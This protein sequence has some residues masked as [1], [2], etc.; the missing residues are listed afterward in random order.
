[1]LMTGS[2]KSVHQ[3][4]SGDSHREQHTQMEIDRNEFSNRLYSNKPVGHEVV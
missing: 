1:L 3:P 4:Y 2:T